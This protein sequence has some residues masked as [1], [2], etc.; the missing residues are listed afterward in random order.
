[1]LP[2]VARL[3]RKVLTMTDP[4]LCR[5]TAAAGM[6]AEASVPVIVVPP[7]PGIGMALM[8]WLVF[9]VAQFMAGIVISVPL[10]ILRGPKI[11]EEM[12]DFSAMVLTTAITTVNLLIAAGMCA[13]LLGKQ[14]P[15]MLA[16]RGMDLRQLLLI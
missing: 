2:L 8:W 6:Q 10:V 15:R 16:L 14:A 13:A 12:D 5:P 7:G 3:R 9:F 1:M 11:L 4:S